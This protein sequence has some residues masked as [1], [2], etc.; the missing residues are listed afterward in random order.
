MVI[1]ENIEKN[2]K[3]SEMHLNVMM[4]LFD[5]HLIRSNIKEINNSNN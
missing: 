4:K 5:V 2:F 1:F 3:K